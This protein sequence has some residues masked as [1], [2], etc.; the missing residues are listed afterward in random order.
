MI[1]DKIMYATYFNAGLCIVDISDPFRPEEIGYYV[2]A[3]PK[4]VK[5]NYVQ[6]DDVY[7]DT[8]GY[9]YLSDRLHGGLWIVQFTGKK[10]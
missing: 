8:K 1:D 6:T 9:I 4:G 2:P 3:P 7:V 10:K 5:E